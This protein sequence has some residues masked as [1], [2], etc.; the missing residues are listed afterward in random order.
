MPADPCPKKVATASSETLSEAQA[1]QLL[2]RMRRLAQQRAERDGRDF[3][4][5]LREIA[6]EMRISEETAAMIQKRNLLLDI[7]ARR[8]A[9]SFV[10]KFS[11]IGD[12]L[13][14]LLEGSARLI[15]GARRSVDYQSKSLEGKYVG[16]LIA[17]LERGDLMTAFRGGNLTREI[18][19]E[20]GEIKDGG[21]PGR[22]GSP[23]AQ[24]IAAI[25]EGVT[26]EMV[27]RE[28]RAGSFINRIPG[29]VVR[30][31]HDMG[32][33]RRVGGG[34][35]SAE[36]R[37]KSLS[38]WTNFTMP[39]LD[40]EATFQGADPL[41]WMRNVHEA[42]FTGVHGPQ[43]GEADVRNL[44]FTQQLP[45][46]ASAQRVLHFKDAESAYLYNQQF[47]LRDL[48]EQVFADI[49][50]RA[51]TTAV[52]EN[53]G[54]SGQG[55][56]DQLI[57]E[58]KEEARLGEDSTK[59]IESLNTWKIQASLDTVTGRSD[60]PVNYTLAK[61]MSV[62]RT[63]E[64]LSKMG[65]TLLS[66][67]SDKAFM[68]HEAAYQGISRLQRWGAQLSGMF[69]RSDERTRFLRLA[70]VAMDGIIGNTISRYTAY[71]GVSGALHRL[72][73]KLFDVNF[74]NWWTDANKATMAE[75]MSAHLGE[76]SSQRFEELPDE[77]RRVLSLYNISRT[78]WDAIR[79]TAW[80]PEGHDTLRISPDQLSRISDDH[81]RSILKEREL[82]DNS[83]N[84]QRVM[85]ELD[86]SLRTYFTDRVDYAIPTPGASERRITTLGTR[87]GTPVGE[88]VRMVMMFKS[89]P[90]SII[91]KIMGREI[92]G[93]GSDSIGQWVLN[94]HR[95]KFNTATLIAM[96]MVAGY[97]SGA[98]KDIL[99][100][101]TPKSLFT[102]DGNIDLS[103]LTDAAARGGGLGIMGDYLFHEYGQG[104][105]SALSQAAGPVISQADSVVEMLQD[106]RRGE[107]RMAAGDA[108]KLL[109]DNTPFINLFYTRPVLD[110]FIFWNLQEM[111]DPGSLRRAEERVSERGQQEFFLRPSEV[112]Q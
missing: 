88:A 10:K 72:Q 29:Y 32:K 109:R 70:G 85:D 48:K 78:S 46:K 108:G 45:R 98:I 76:H 106:F 91:S 86:T 80:T 50:H 31:T 30:Q 24:R 21:R 74:M 102:E 82:N 44:F 87:P 39:L 27:S 14:A 107:G 75:L 8:E 42:L 100:G 99:K 5:A 68:N 37:A 60:I 40:V 3:N 28:N 73:Q 26:D 56:W 95:G 97:M 35:T 49:H 101:R 61:S 20:M 55:N 79:S 12:G 111:M 57:R 81:V 9:K 1:G 11:T 2:D 103:T 69:S 43:S 77:L 66:A 89:F 64:V 67:F 36:S 94:N 6:G 22:S 41:L 65:S 16:R 15:Q 105:R 33:I 96:T 17:E 58:L 4:Q 52:M 71:S 93:A 59:Q 19:I 25:I 53:I 34:G 62:V 112:A 84:R 38:E 51:R 7:R 90:I 83:I 104:Q 23:E 63:V 13:L 18:Y 92:Y 47:G 110:Y 54:P